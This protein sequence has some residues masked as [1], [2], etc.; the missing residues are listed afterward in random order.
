MIITEETRFDKND[1][2]L[3]LIGCSSD[4]GQYGNHPLEKGMATHSSIL[5]WRSPWTE[6]PIVCGQ[7]IDRAYRPKAIVHG[8]AEVLETIE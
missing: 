6:E 4:L 8:L 1:D 7:T 5:A 2:M 3:A